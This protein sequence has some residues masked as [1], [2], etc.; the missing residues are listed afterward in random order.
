MKTSILEDRFLYE[1][2]E[3]VEMNN[4]INI[5]SDKIEQIK[6]ENLNIS[7]LDKEF[8]KNFHFKK[9]IFSIE[10]IEILSLT[11]NGEYEI[12]VKSFIDNKNFIFITDVLSIYLIYITNKF[13][14]NNPHLMM[15]IYKSNLK[16]SDATYPDFNV[17]THF[18][19]LKK[20]INNFLDKNKSFLVYSDIH[21]GEIANIKEN[22]FKSKTILEI[23]KANDEIINNVL[24]RDDGLFKADFFKALNI[25]EENPVLKICKIIKILEC[26][27]FDYNNYPKNDPTNSIIKF[28][29]ENKIESYTL[30]NM[31]LSDIFKK[32]NF[33]SECFCKLK[34]N[35]EKDRI[36]FVI[37]LFMDCIGYKTDKTFRTNISSFFDELHLEYAIKAKFFMTRDRKL[38]ERAKE[39][40]NFLKS[41]TKVIIL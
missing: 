13:K 14:K 26:H 31:T 30:N 1:I 2:K 19:E 20:M 21:T 40:F 12:Y 17:L 24:V 27:K 16:I 6:D 22:E 32:Y 23:K 4:I 7:F 28:I 33:L 9:D 25:A 37:M 29:R 10:E 39:I 41:K 3:F 34:N 38:G 11:Y 5:L 15:E 18:S 36:V 8:L 35:F